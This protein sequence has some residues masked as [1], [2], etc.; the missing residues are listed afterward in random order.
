MKVLLSI[1]GV[2]WL[3]APLQAF[4]AVPNALDWSVAATLPPAPGQQKQIGLAGVGGGLHNQVLLVA[5]GANFPDAMPWE[6]GRKKYWPDIYVLLKKDNGAYEWHGRTFQLPEPLAYCASVATAKGILLIGGEN[7][8]GI[9]S[10]VQLLEWDA[11]KQEVLV[12][13]M[14]ALPLQLTNAAAALLGD[15]V[16]V[17]GGETTGQASARLYRLNL[18][19]P[20]SAWE[21]LPEMPM[22]LSHAVAVVQSNGEYPCLYLLGGRTQNPSGISALHGSTFQFDP[23]K[24]VWQRLSDITDGKGNKTALS[25]ATGAATG[26]TNILVF[27]GDKGTVFTQIEQYNAAIAAASDEEQKQQL[28]AKKLQ[29]LTNHAGFSKDIYLY[30]TVT[31]AWTTMGLLPSSHVTTFAAKWGDDILIP[32]GEIKPGVRTPVVLRGNMAPKH[33]FAW[34]DYLVLGIYL[35]LMVAIGLWTSKNQ[36]TTDDY[37]RGGQRIPGWAAGLSIYG[38][39]LSAITFMSIP[40]KTYATNWNYFFLQM[41]IIMVIPVITNYFIPFYRKLQI[42]SAYEYLE[43]RF[44]YAARACASLLYILLQLG[45]LAIV[46]LL[47]SLAL[48]LVTG[49]NVN[50]CILL[51][52]GIT[53]FYT[54]KGGIEAVVWT[55]VAQV[56]VLL[57]GALLCLI[58]IPLQLSG[59]AASLWE[60]IREEDKLN[61]FNTT[62]SFSEPTLWVVLLGGFAINVI[63]YGADQSVVQKYLTTKD[64]AA[65]KRSLRLGAWMALPSALI[66]FSIGTMLYLFFKENPG[67]VNFQL[68]SQDAIFPWYIVTELPPGLTGL[69]IAAVFAAAMSTLSSSMN[70]V[71]TAFITDFYRRF[72]PSKTEKRYLATARLTTLTVGVMGTVLAL[73]LARWGIS[74]LWDQFNTILGLFTGGLGGLFVLGI[75]TKRANARGAVSGLLLSGL[76]QFYL[77]RYTSLNFLM[78]AFT[79]LV[80]CVLFGYL[81][82]LLFGGQE[83]DIAGLTAYKVKASEKKEIP[84]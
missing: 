9:Q 3:S 45:R 41:T 67:K 47:P 75:F 15:Q 82:S 71:T 49:I 1:L 76:V 64:E 8:Q 43:K 19:A 7:E 84:V 6:G 52:G 40:A 53:I 60:T 28:Q 69:L 36:G 2:L 39:Q 37:F 16:Y 81:C 38:T 79:G 54:M 31:N 29:L 14:P 61:I 21:E 22:A 12:K 68:Q 4:Q 62:F 10:A 23:K 5:G 55:D 58:L 77:S 51:M 32:S 59:D 50:L 25:A 26:A 56:V 48:T 27:G 30:N 74:S 73:V 35:L 24:A 72:F 63:T 44:N 34:L 11:L 18:S 42:T 46:L 66:F 80:A 20:A 57:G 65:S 17:A 83:K 78:Y 13:L 33:Y 70:S